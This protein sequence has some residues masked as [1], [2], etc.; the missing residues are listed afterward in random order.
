MTALEREAILIMFGETWRRKFWP[1]DGQ[2]G[3]P[4]ISDCIDFALRKKNSHHQE[5][6]VDFLENYLSDMARRCQNMT[7]R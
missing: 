2:K 3:R 7:R 1:L 4:S 6:L 5:D